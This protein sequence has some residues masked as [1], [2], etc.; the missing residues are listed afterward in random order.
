MSSFNRNYY[1]SPPQFPTKTLPKD[2]D[3]LGQAPGFDGIMGKVEHI[4]DCM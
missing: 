3:L 2:R 4:I 1:N